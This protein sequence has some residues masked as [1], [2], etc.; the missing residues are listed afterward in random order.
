M[1]ER[2]TKHPTPQQA[3][4]IYKSFIENGSTYEINIGQAIRSHIQNEFDRSNQLQNPSTLAVPKN[5][6]SK[7]EETL[8]V[9]L[10]QDVFPRFCESERWQKFLQQSL[11][12]ILKI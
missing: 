6:F 11:H 1:V 10:K 8:L 4:E 12:Q 7:A 5:V 3:I 9:V 2:F